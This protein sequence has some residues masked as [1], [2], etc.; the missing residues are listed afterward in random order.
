MRPLS[1]QRQHSDPMTAVLAR[2]SGVDSDAVHVADAVISVW[3]DIVA[4]LQTIIGRQGVAALYDRSVSLA[5]GTYPWLAASLSGPDNSLD[6]AAL[7]SAI[8]GRSNEEAAAGSG[9]LLQTFYD[10]LASLI[11]PALCDQ[12]LSVVREG[13]VHTVHE[14]AKP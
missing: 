11:G 2:R 12:L 8:A 10:V 5:S 6:L 13:S 14:I 3:Q 4:V 1:S 7:R 9:E